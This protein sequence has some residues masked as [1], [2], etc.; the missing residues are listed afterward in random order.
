LLNTP[1]RLQMRGLVLL[2]AGVVQAQPGRYDPSAQRYQEE[3]L[4]QQLRQQASQQ[5]QQQQAQYARQAQQEALLRAQREAMLKQAQR[6]NG[7]YQG[8]S[9][10]NDGGSKPPLSKKEQRE[11]KKKQEKDAKTLQE[12]QKTNQKLRQQA[13]KKRYSSSSRRAA[14]GA[15]RGGLPGFVLSWKGLA[16][17]GG[18]AVLY[19]TQRELLM[20]TL[21]KY[22][23]WLASWVCRAVWSLAI[24]PVVRFIILRTKGGGMLPGG[25]Y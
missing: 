15:K 17:T 1:R 23:V 20:G 25:S 8:G 9:F 3:L 6:G 5:Q 16:L 18:L 24:K 11:L 12:L 19:F 21:L 22:P 2:L 10:Y 4:R 13:A 14:S 7:G